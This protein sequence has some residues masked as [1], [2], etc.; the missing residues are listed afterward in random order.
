MMAVAAVLMLSAGPQAQRA[1]EVRPAPTRPGLTWAAADALEAKLAEIERV[2]VKAR[3]TGA[4]P[5]SVEVT[6]PELNSYLNLTLGPKIPPELSEV[7][8]RIEPTQI[9]GVGLLD[10]D[11]LKA[12]IPASG[13]FNPLSFL[14]GRVPVDLKTALPSANG[15]GT[16]AV[17][18][19]TLGGVS[20][21]MSLVQQIVLSA[22]RSRD[23]PGGFDV[24]SPFRL[25]YQVKQVRLGAGKA[26]LEY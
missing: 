19:L 17:K 3:R 10:L 1:P 12:K 5:R 14:G 22:T 8:L 7:S 15:M 13:P 26:W 4:L 16:L 6:E 24:Q 2:A 23:N 9:A 11:R 18:E 20:I 21:P 25:P